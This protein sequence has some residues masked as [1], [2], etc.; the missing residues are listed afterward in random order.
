MTQVLVVELLL[1]CHAM[2][3]S[4]A[5]A[6]TEGRVGAKADGFRLGPQPECDDSF[7]S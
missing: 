5:H 3:L 1:A 2:G 7:H 6:G 4:I